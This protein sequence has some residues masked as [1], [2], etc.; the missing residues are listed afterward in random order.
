MP[1][2]VNKR[3]D[4]VV[5]C[6]DINIIR[7]W[8][9][10]VAVYDDTGTGMLYSCALYSVVYLDICRFRPSTFGLSRSASLVLR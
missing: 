10:A 4:A 6:F 3:L 7:F 5:L 1:V 8:R 9:T 2:L